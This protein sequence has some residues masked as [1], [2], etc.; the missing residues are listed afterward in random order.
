MDP[1]FKG[2]YYYK[3]MSCLFDSL[4]RFIQDER[5]DGAIVRKVICEYLKSDPKMIDDMTASEVIKNET[6]LNL[7]QYISNMQMG[8]TFGGAIEIRAF[9]RVFKLNVL[10]NSIPNK[11]EIE[12]VENKRYRWAVLYW[13]GNHYEAVELRSKDLDH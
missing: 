8:S 3:I 6:G 11:K 5:V 10:V 7:E 9:T 2:V 4:A 13:T 1:Y 12:F